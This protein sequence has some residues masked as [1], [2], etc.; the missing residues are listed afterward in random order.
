MKLDSFVYGLGAVFLGAIGLWFGEYALQ[1]QPVPASWPLHTPLAYASAVLLLLTGFLVLTGRATGFTVSLLGLFYASWVIALHLPR[2]LAEPKAVYL[3][4]GFAE[5]A[6]LTA[7][8]IVLFATTSNIA[9]L[10]LLVFGR[11]VFGLSAIVFGYSHYVYVKETAAFIP[12]YFP[13]PTYWA[14][15]TG[16]G[17]A[18]AGIAILTGVAR[19]YAAPAL[20][21][22][23]GSFVV[24]VHVARIYATPTVH[25]EWVS[26]G[27]ATGL[28]GAALLMRRA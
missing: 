15:A 19:K 26:L 9:R 24:L 5:I 21:A 2:V 4:L 7:G 16:L 17:H 13:E 23:M 11:I 20:A 25:S 18:L 12:S 10:P 8:G 14:Y 27:I 6:A 22:M 28:T 3:W 1:W